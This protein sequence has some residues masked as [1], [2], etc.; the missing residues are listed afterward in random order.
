VVEPRTAEEKLDHFVR[1]CLGLVLVQGGS[2]VIEDYQRRLLRD[3]FDGARETIVLISK[4]NGKTTLLAALGLY[5]VCSTIEAECVIGA[6]SRD[7]ASILFDQAVGFVVRSPGLDK[8]VVPKRGFREIRSL[9]RGG[10]MRVLAADVD[11]VDG[12]IPTLALVDELGR[13]KKP[14]LYGVFRDGL[15]PRGGQMVTISTAG[16]FE[17]STLGQIRAAALKL[18]RVERDGKYAYARSTDN[19]GFALHE[20]A[21]SA[22]DDL[23][24]LELVKQVNPA[25]WQTVDELKTRHDSPSTFSWQ[26]ARFACGVWLAVGGAWVDPHDWWAS[27]RATLELVPGDKITLGFDG[28]RFHDATAIVACRLSDGLLQTIKV[29]EAPEHGRDWEVPANEVDATIADTMERYKVVRAYFDP[30]LWQSEIDG[31]AAEYGDELVL[32]FHTNRSRMMAA[33]ERFRTDLASGL[34]MHA[35][36]ETLSR[37][38]LNVHLREARG[39]YWLAKGHGH[40]D[41]AVAAV[42][43]YEARCDV[44]ASGYREV[45]KVPV[46]F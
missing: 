22:E 28:S 33:T 5:H 29:W 7:Q 16:D 25:S 8:L 45:S 19:G 37:H 10:R 2:L 43:A 18:P 24:D 44:A 3:Y 38:V 1:F 31:W 14:D 41:A 20:W 9:K 32:R 40:I 35:G 27:E 26:W 21:L 39:G 13:H 4:K 36:D 12:V 34:I 15:G 46:S 42:L 11:H 23:D 6:S 17:L 30:P